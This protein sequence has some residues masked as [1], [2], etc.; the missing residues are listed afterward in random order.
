MKA[1][2]R[3]YGTD[4]RE[5]T[6]IGSMMLG[7]IGGNSKIGMPVEVVRRAPLVPS[8]AWLAYADGTQ[9]MGE[10]LDPNYSG[11]LAFP[12]VRSTLPEVALILV[13]P[14]VTA[15]DWEATWRVEFTRTVGTQD[16]DG[17]FQVIGTG[18][19][20]VAD[21]FD[22]GPSGVWEGSSS[23]TATEDGT[24]VNLYLYGDLDEVDPPDSSWQIGP[25]SFLRLNR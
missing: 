17:L 9:I 11:L 3:L 2:S 10:D 25:E 20:V 1:G 16:A 5:D 24:S 13:F 4:E 21:F 18:P 8:G 23:F 22:L 12:D 7:T 19:P 14:T 15:G 6:A